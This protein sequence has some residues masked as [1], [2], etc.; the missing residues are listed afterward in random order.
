[1]Y[2]VVISNYFKTTPFQFTKLNSIIAHSKL[3]P[4]TRCICLLELLPE[5]S[6]N[7]TH[8]HILGYTRRILYF[9][10]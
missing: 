5:I 7:K 4:R 3:H 6:Y 10:I 9:M 8:T 2:Y 1:M